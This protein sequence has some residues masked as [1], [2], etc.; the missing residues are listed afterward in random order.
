[1]LIADMPLSFHECRATDT[2]LLRFSHYADARLFYERYAISRY[3]A[4][5]AGE[6][7]YGDMLLRAA[8]YAITRYWLCLRYDSCFSRVITPLPCRAVRRRCVISI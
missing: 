2:P 5:H 1:M 7:C 6:A 3:A 8:P 4:T